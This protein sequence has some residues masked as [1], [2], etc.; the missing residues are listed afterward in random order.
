MPGQIREAY[1]ELGQVLN[2]PEAFGLGSHIPRQLAAK[3]ESTRRMLR[4]GIKEQQM[5]PDEDLE[6]ELAQDA[7]RDC[8]QQR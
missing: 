7:D 8:R 5:P 2:H 4:Q 3:L 6:I 1:E